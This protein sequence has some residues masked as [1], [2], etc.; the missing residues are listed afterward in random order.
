MLLKYYQV[1]YYQTLFPLLFGANKTVEYQTTTCFLLPGR[2][3]T[4][5]SPLHLTYTLIKSNSYL[6]TEEV[7][8]ANQNIIVPKYSQQYWLEEDLL[9]SL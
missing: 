1:K 5:G 8:L 4:L 2:V 7:W 6:T 9:Y 3:A